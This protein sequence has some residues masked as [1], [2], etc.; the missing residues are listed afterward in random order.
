MV[1]LVDG[2]ILLDY[3]NIHL[4]YVSFYQMIFGT[5]DGKSLLAPSNY[6]DFRERSVGVMRVVQDSGKPFRI[7][8]LSLINF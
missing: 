3:G 6:D 1:S 4:R 5:R 7:L 2:K 8:E